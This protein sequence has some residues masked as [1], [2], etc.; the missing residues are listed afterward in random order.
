MSKRYDV[1]I[2]G[3]EPAGSYHD[4]NATGGR[5][6]IPS[7]GMVPILR[8]EPYCEDCRGDCT[9]ACAG[10]YV[11][12]QIESHAATRTRPAPVK[13]DAPLLPPV[14]EQGNDEIPPPPAPLVETTSRGVVLTATLFSVRGEDGG[15]YA[16]VEMAAHWPDGRV[17]RRMRG[18]ETERLTRM[19]RNAFTLWAEAMREM[20]WSRRT[21]SA[22]RWFAPGTKPPRTADQVTVTAAMIMPGLNTGYRTGETITIPAHLADDQDVQRYARLLRRA[23]DV[24][25]EWHDQVQLPAPECPE[26]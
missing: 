12:G 3:Y 2:I 10:L 6:F 8:A 4:T 16:A 14:D 23:L 11:P 22:G 7:G 17:K 1:E 15:V 5:A 18:D 26:D 9:G 25:R 19:E 24:A 13:V 21:N 20:G